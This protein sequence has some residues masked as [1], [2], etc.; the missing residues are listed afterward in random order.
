MKGVERH[1]FFMIELEQIFS[2]I[3]ASFLNQ[4]IFLSIL[5]QDNKF[6]TR[7]RRMYLEKNP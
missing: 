7:C 6:Y 3:F 4:Q 1:P 2:K 5:Y